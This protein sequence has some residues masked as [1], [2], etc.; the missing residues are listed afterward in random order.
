LSSFRQPKLRLVRPYD[1]QAERAASD[2]EYFTVYKAAKGLQWLTE[3]AGWSDQ[4]RAA[5]GIAVYA[6]T[7]LRDL[8]RR[9]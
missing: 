5:R 8:R 3:K 2:W 6:L 1:P 4:S 9:P 7:Q